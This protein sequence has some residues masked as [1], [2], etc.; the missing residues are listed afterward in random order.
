M[1]H[2]RVGN[3]NV[4][5]VM[6]IMIYVS[7]MRKYI[8]MY[9]QTHDNWQ[10]L[11]SLNYLQFSHPIILYT[12]SIK[13]CEMWCQMIRACVHFRYWASVDLVIQIHLFGFFELISTIWLSYYDRRQNS[14]RIAG[15]KF[16]PDSKLSRII[17]RKV[18]H[19]YDWDKSGIAFIQ[20]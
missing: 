14:S 8:A 11:D 9:H 4:G 17:V 13:Y 12:S 16:H 19:I 10:W 15:R 1:E 7:L 2:S 5:I 6:T 18:F 3:K 20:D